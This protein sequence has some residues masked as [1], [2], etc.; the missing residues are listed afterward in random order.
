[1]VYTQQIEVKLVAIKTELN[2]GSVYDPFH[3]SRTLPL[4]SS[5]LGTFKPLSED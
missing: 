4:K 5:M 1:M 2:L 3:F